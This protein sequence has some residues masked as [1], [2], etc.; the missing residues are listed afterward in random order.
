MSSG[1]RAPWVE[2]QWIVLGLSVCVRE[3]KRWLPH[4][5][6]LP[7]AWRPLASRPSARPWRRPMSTRARSANAWE[8]WSICR[9]SSARSCCACASCPAAF[10]AALGRLLSL[11]TAYDCAGT[12]TVSSRRS[13]CA[14]GWATDRSTSRT[15]GRSCCPTA[16]SPSPQETTSTSVTSAMRTPLASRRHASH[17][18]RSRA[19]TRLDGTP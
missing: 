11:L 12:M 8:R 15:L 7:F 16:S 1:P 2:L 17:R 5:A 19:L 6:S 9:R 3:K 14:A 18:T 10:S 13:S 4:L